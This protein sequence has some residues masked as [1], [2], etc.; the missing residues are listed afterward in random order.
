[1]KYSESCRAKAQEIW[2]PWASLPIISTASPLLS[3]E[4]GLLILTP[5]LSYV[6]L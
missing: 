1:M 2:V 4:M 6:E 5:K 3:C